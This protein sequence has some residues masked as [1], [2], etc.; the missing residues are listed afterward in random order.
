MGYSESPPYVGEM[1]MP[2]ISH[3]DAALFGV[4]PISGVINEPG[5]LKGWAEMPP[6]RS[7]G[8]IDQP[9]VLGDMGMPPALGDSSNPPLK[10]IMDNPP[11]IGDLETVP[12]WGVIVDPPLKGVMGT[13][14]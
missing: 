8:V 10:G 11:A 6:V 7:F 4:I 14:A 13:G 2:G 1:H 5:V 3:T 9:T 12:F